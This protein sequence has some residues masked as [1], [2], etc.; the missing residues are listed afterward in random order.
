[1]KTQNSLFW[2]HPHGMMCG[3]GD[4]DYG[5]GIRAAGVGDFLAVPVGR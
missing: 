4:G 2:G 3:P 5:V 1:M